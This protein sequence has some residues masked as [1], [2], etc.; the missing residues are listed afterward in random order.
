MNNKLTFTQSDKIKVAIITTFTLTLIVFIT[1]L[2]AK[3]I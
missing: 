3:L 2:S 1:L